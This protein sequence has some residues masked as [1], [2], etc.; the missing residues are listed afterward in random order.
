MKMEKNKRF[1]ITSLIA[2]VRKYYP[3]SVG[4]HSFMAPNAVAHNEIEIPM[5]QSRYGGPIM[6]L[7]PGLMP[8]DHL[9]F[10]AQLDLAALAPHDPLGLL[11]T[12]GQLLF[13]ADIR[14]DQGAVYYSE[15][16]N[17]SLQRWVVE[18]DDNFFEGIVIT[19]F[20][21]EE[22][23]W[24][25]RFVVA[26]AEEAEFADADGQ[27]WDFIAGSDRSK[28]YGLWTHC[29]YLPEQIERAWTDDKIVLIQV[30]TDGFNSEGVFSVLIPKH[31]LLKRDFSSCEFHWAQS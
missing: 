29:Q 23:T 4:F 15:A 3:A 1:S 6:D 9:R 30:G 16:S 8:P 31:D 22:E 24:G 21:Q 17:E 25:E 7:P 5:G 19:G 11:P 20:K 27:I 14:A 18:H 26:T 10:A 12:H 28:I 2:D 13:F